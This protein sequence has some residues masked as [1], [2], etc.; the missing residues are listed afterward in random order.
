MQARCSE[1]NDRG[2]TLAAALVARP[3]VLLH[4]VGRRET[5]ATVPRKELTG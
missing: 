4:A 2:V 3:C 5:A 1:S